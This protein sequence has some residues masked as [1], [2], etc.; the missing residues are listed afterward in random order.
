MAG[1]PTSRSLEVLRERG[2]MAAVTEKWNPY[3]RIRQDLFGIVDLVAVG[4]GELVMVQ[5]TS[6]SNVSSRLKK[7]ADSPVLPLLREAGVRLLVHGW[8]KKKGRWVLREE[9]IS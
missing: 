2:Y 9:D 6:A 1:S 5:T 8:R 3:A 7:I 4:K